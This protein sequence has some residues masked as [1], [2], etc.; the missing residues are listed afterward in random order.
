VRAR[1]GLIKCTELGLS[2][3]ELNILLPIVDAN[4]SDSGAFDGVL[5]LLIRAG[6]SLPEAMMMMIPEAWQNDPNM[7][8]ARR[9]LYQYHSALMEPWDGPALISFTDGHF[10]GATLDRNGLRPGRYYVTH[11]GRVI[12]ASEVGVVDV[13]DDDVERKGRLSPGMMLLVDFEKVADDGPGGSLELSL[14]I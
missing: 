8:P 1:E 11:S 9:A 10:L 6:R 7:D 2:E 5:E 14:S 3:E 13:P 12:M 4:S